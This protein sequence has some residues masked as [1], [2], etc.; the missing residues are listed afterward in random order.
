MW[1]KTVEESFH[2]TCSFLT[3]MGRN[4]MVQNPDKFQFCEMEVNWS[5]FLIRRDSVRPMPHLT[6]VIRNFLM[7]VNRTDLRSFMALAQ[8]VS[9][10]TAVAPVLLPFR[11]LLKERT[12][13]EWTDSMSQTFMAT[14]EILA[15]RVEEGI[16]MFDPYK[17]IL[18]TCRCV[19]T[20]KKP[21]ANCCK[22]GWRV[23]MVR[24][25]FTLPAEINYAPTEG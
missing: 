9:Y 14:R 6:N 1:G 3:L 4:G 13:W 18:L 11:A 10:S 17:V 2:K 22:E 7:P 8:Q 23:C 19:I 20:G 5:R 24:S 15:D 12:P 25:R 16:K 21:N